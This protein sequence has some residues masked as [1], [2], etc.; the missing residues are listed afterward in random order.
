MYRQRRG[1]A[2]PLAYASYPRQ[3]MLMAMYKAFHSLPSFLLLSKRYYA[4]YRLSCFFAAVQLAILFSKT[5][6]PVI[7]YTG[8]Q[9]N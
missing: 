8:H 6:I 2:P 7:L 3:Q 9:L 4:L 1:A 5:F